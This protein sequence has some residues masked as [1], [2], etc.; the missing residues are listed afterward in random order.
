MYLIGNEG[1]MS[2]TQKKRL[3]R[4]ALDAVTPDVLE[5]LYRIVFHAE[6]GL[7]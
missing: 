7:E 5:L 6:S 4:E 2:D 1:G 3:I